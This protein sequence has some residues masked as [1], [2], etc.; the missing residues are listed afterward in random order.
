MNAPLNLTLQ[1]ILTVVAGIGAQVLAEFLLVPGIVFLL[2]FGILLGPS[3]SGL[4]SPEMF[5]EGLEVIVA[6]LVA[7]V[8]FEGGFSLKLKEL[9]KVSVSLR[10]LVTVGTVVNLLGGAAAAHWL[11]E[12]PWP[13]AFLFG[14]L[15]VVTGPVTINS[16]LKQVKVDRSVAT[17]L[18]GEGVFIDPLGA[19]LAFAILNVVLN[20]NPNPLFVMGDLVLRL[21]IGAAIGGIAGWLLGQILQR[22]TF[23]SDDL[24]ALVV[25]AGVWGSFG[26]SQTLRSEAGLMAVVTSG[27]FL[28]NLELS[29][30]RLLKR[31][32]GQ[33]TTLSVSVLF[34]LLAAD[35]PIASVFALGWEG[36]ATVLVLM[37]VIRPAYVWLCTRKSAL[38]WRQKT[39]IAWIAPR[40]I[41]SASVASLFAILLT[42]N[43]INGGDATKALVFLTILMTVFLQALTAPWLANWL[44]ITS[45]Q[46]T[47]IVI[48]GAN[49]ISMLIANQFLQQGEYVAILTTDEAKV[50]I[51]PQENLQ[52]STSSAIAPEALEEV[53]IEGLGTFLALTESSNVNAVI[54]KQAAEEFGPPRVVAA[55]PSDAESASA[56]AVKQAFNAKFDCET[57]IGYAQAGALRFGCTALQAD[58]AAQQAHIQSLI[59]SGMLLPLML[60]QADKLTVATVGLDLD[61]DGQLF[62]LFHDPKPKLL[63]R[64]S[65]GSQPLLVAE[66]LVEVE[67]IPVPEPVLEPEPEAVVEL[68]PEIALTP[69]VELPLDEA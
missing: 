62:Y 57:W 42:Q 55:F 33:L 51:A 11:S 56:G 41:V 16:I 32:K 53:G 24:K 49:P 6:L 52:I 12:F 65:G 54:A 34:I 7:I 30:E 28:R 19:I 43:G 26:I 61:Q 18:E 17:I 27:I 63:K 60:Q 68:T 58:S 48:V 1:I 45:T 29:E 20:G 69:T 10:N 67:T 35:L 66:Q 50:K 15:V 25:L 64:L 9:S 4:L 37:F 31:F 40:G 47:G 3:F 38:N 2:L 59:E 13:I 22:G 8:L 46:A 5:G 23:L 14:A 39:F 44:E 21:G 36:V